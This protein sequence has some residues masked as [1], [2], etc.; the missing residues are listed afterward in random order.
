MAV[1]VI[2]AQ[3]RDPVTTTPAIHRVVID[4]NYVRVLETRGTDDLSRVWPDLTNL[5]QPDNLLPWIPG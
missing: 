1:S 3:S 2:S 5:A 4:N